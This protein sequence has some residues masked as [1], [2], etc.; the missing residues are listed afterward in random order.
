[1]KLSIVRRIENKELIVIEN[2]KWRRRMNCECEHCEWM[3]RKNEQMRMSKRLVLQRWAHGELTH[4]VSLRFDKKVIGIVHCHVGRCIDDWCHGEEHCICCD[5]WHIST[6]LLWCFSGAVMANVVFS[7][8]HQC[9][10][11]LSPVWPETSKIGTGLFLSL[12]V[13]WTA[14]VGF[15]C[16]G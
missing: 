8:S 13:S 10:I 16:V 7:S 1:M 5:H 9:V 4:S 3:W 15:Q 11:S 2:D 6:G 14:L 12:N